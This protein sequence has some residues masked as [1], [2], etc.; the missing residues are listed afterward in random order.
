M[1][2]AAVEADNVFAAGHK[3]LPPVVLDGALEFDA[4]RS[5]V[6]KSG[7][8]VVNVAARK[9]EAAAFAQTDNLVHGG[10]RH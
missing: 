1:N 4:N 9:N 3:G 10:C 2:D 7:V 5:V 8:A 6:V